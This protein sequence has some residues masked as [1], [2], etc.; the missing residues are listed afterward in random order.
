MRLP[1]C[2]DRPK[3]RDSIAAGTG[4][5]GSDT[6]STA[7]RAVEPDDSGA[8]TLAD[9]WCRRSSA[10]RVPWSP[11]V[12]RGVRSDR[13]SRPRRCRRRT[14]GSQVVAHPVRRWMRTVTAARG[15][16]NPDQGPLPVRRRTTAIRVV[17]RRRATATG[18]D[19]TGLPRDAGRW[20]RTSTVGRCGAPAAPWRAR[21][22]CSVSRRTASPCSRRRDRCPPVRS[23]DPGRSGR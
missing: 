2:R 7:G 10:A 13:R 8:G 1:R 18:P 9:G 15:R 16:D 20:Y 14:P 11:V 21:T 4:A 19:R 3:R 23:A 22:T 12:R 6:R 5:S 17:V